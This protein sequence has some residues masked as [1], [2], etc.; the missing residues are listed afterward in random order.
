MRSALIEEAHQFIMRTSLRNP[1]SKELVYVY[2]A[3][4]VTALA[5]GQILKCKYIERLGNIELPATK[6]KLPPLTQTERNKRSKAN[7]SINEWMKYKEKSQLYEEESKTPII[8][9][10][11]SNE[12]ETQ[13]DESQDLEDTRLIR[14]TTCQEETATRPEDFTVLE[15]A[16]TQK[17]ISWLRSEATIAEGDKDVIPRFTLTTFKIK[18]GESGY[19]KQEHFDKAYGLAWDI[20]G[21]CLSRD[22]FIKLYYTNAGPLQKRSFIIMNSFNTSP[23]DPNRYRVIF[24]FLEPCKSLE[25]LQTI[26]D[27]LAERITD[28]GMTLEEAGLDTN[29]RAGNQI[30]H[31][32]RKNRRFPDSA[33]FETYG[34]RTQKLERYG[35]R[36]NDY[37][38]LMAAAKD[39][40]GALDKSD[41]TT[42]PK[43]LK[44]IE[45]EISAI[46]SMHQNRRGPLYTLCLKLYYNG[47]SSGETYGHLLRVAGNDPKMR[48]MAYKAMCSLHTRVKLPKPP[49]RR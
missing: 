17:F 22:G 1:E 49:R 29:S 11:N 33:F 28:A 31:L 47:F 46:R 42:D 44:D 38:I 34:T 37:R 7:K 15:F 43:F 48:E 25:V 13:N 16:S 27:S 36:P 41:K 14:V 32:P 24:L 21:G 9:R 23:D 4:K 6:E 12:I 8:T 2:V 26:H 10:E 3:D 39:W 40:S 45:D 5:I 18:Q 19:R 20:D 30:Y 35:I